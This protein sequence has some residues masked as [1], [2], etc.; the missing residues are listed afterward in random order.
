MTLPFLPEAVQTERQGELSVRV[1][2]KSSELPAL[3]VTARKAGIV[4]RT[5]VVALTD[6]RRRDQYWVFSKTPIPNTNGER[7]N[8][9]PKRRKG[10][11]AS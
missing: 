7:N 9:L 1:Q 11:M 10:P 3:R 5:V 6:D 2:I 8:H 4:Y